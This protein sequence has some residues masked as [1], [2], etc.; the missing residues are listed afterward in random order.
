MREEKRKNFVVILKITMMA[1]NNLWGRT[2]FDLGSYARQQA[3]DD[4]W[5]LKSP[6]SVSTAKNEVDMA[7]SLAEADA[8]LAKFGWTEEVAVAA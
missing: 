1:C 4:S 7:P 3:E 5:P 6:I 2:G 8:I